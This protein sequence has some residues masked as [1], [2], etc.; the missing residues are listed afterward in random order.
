MVGPRGDNNPR[1]HNE[2]ARLYEF[3]QTAVIDETTMSDFNKTCP[4]A[5]A[6]SADEIEARRVKVLVVGEL[7]DETIG[8][9]ETAEYGDDGQPLPGGGLKQMLS[10]M[11]ASGVWDVESEGVI[12]EPRLIP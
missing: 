8:S 10:D 4:A 2:L 5:A 1:I 6:L 11:A 3:H 9:I 12:T 7:D